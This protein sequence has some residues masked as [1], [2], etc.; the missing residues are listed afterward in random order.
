MYTTKNFDE[1]VAEGYK[2]SGY[3]LCYIDDIGSEI[4]GYSKEEDRYVDQPNPDF[5]AGEQEYYAYFTPVSL[6]EQWGDDWDDYPYNENAEIPYDSLYKEKDKN[7]KWKEYEIL[8]VPFYLPN[9]IVYF[10][11]DWGYDRCQFSVMDI[12]AGAVAWVYYTGR[13][14]KTTRGSVVI[15]AGDNPMEF[16]EKVEKINKDIDD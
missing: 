16:V 10:A 8:R 9:A 2:Y 4:W 15:K 12:N 7:G 1:I 3:K 11:K 5:I 6:E 13:N 14:S